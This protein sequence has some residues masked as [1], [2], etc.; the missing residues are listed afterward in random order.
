MKRHIFVFLFDKRLLSLFSR[1]IIF[2]TFCFTC[3][4]SQNYLPKKHRVD[5]KNSSSRSKDKQ[6]ITKKI[7]KTI[8]NILCSSKLNI[9]YSSEQKQTKT[10]FPSVVWIPPYTQITLPLMPSSTTVTTE[11]LLS[12]DSTFYGSKS[13][14]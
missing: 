3:W 9:F 7:D 8:K 5:Q 11:Y 6:N 12:P 10:V 2:S 14:L 1:K 4:N 13:N